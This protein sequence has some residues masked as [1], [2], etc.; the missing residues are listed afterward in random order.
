MT[1]QVLPLHLHATADRA[2]EFFH[3]NHGVR[4]IAAEEPLADSIEWRPTISGVTTDFHI[5]AVEVTDGGYTQSLD[6]AIVQCINSGLPV[7]LYIVYPGDDIKGDDFM[8]TF[9]DALKRGV[10][11]VEVR[12]ATCALVKP[13]LDLSLHSVRRVD[14]KQFAKKRRQA[15]L[16]AESTFLGGDPVKGC[17]RVYEQVE[18]LSRGLA[19]KAQQRGWWSPP[20]KLK[21]SKG[22]WATVMQEL[23]KGVNVSLLRGACPNIDESLLNR[24][25]GLTDPRNQFAH[26]PRNRAALI[27]RDRRLR[28]YYEHAID[29]LEEL[30][31]GVRR[32]RI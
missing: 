13:A 9:R 17:L 14:S 5:V 4:K 29:V 30:D 22:P 16:D 31:R 6:G 15:V 12:G 32:L 19:E 1:Y 3:G 18:S 27:K 10:G 11:I 7:R 2:K 24:I 21:I 26:Q 28:T 25:A 8:R 23:I 20:A